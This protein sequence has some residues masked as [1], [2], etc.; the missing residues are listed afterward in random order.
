MEQN[1]DWA[2][3]E[4]QISDSEIATLR[5]DKEFIAFIKSQIKQRVYDTRLYRRTWKTWISEAT[6]GVEHTVPYF[7]DVETPF[8]TGSGFMRHIFLAYGWLRFRPLSYVEPNAKTVKSEYWRI[9]LEGYRSF[10]SADKS[11]CAQGIIKTVQWLHEQYEK[12]KESQEAA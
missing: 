3:I 4:A 6:R 7:K 5:G 1:I 10:Y 12:S 11:P 8:V 2:S 9:P